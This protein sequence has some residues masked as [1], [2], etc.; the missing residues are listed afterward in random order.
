MP[1]DLQPIPQKEVYAPSKVQFQKKHPY[2]VP[3]Q[4]RQVMQFHDGNSY[5]VCP[6]CDCTIE[7]EYMRYCDRC[8]QHLKWTT[9]SFAKV[10]RS[11]GDKTISR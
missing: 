6:R 5:P 9:F 4:V 7:R 3:M 1:L 11:K 2:R 8:G 10:R